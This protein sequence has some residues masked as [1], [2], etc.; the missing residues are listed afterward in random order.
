MATISV[1]W[2]LKRD[3]SGRGYESVYIKYGMFTEWNFRETLC[4]HGSTCR[5]ILFDIFF[6]HDARNGFRKLYSVAGTY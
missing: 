2:S 3:C 6:W 1:K 5:Y 4:V